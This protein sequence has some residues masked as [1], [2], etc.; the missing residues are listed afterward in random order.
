MRTA[1][2][3]RVATLFTTRIKNPINNAKTKARHEEERIHVRKTPD[4]AQHLLNGTALDA[5][6]TDLLDVPRAE[7]ALSD[8]HPATRTFKEAAKE[9]TQSLIN[10]AL[11]SIVLSLF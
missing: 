9:R 5:K 7:L 10:R 1:S 2:R 6:V 8:E 11:M 3:S 4:I